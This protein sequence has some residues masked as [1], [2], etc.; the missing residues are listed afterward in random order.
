MERENA[1]VHTMKSI[2]LCL[3]YPF[4]YPRN[5]FTDRH[6]EN[7]K[8]YEYLNG[9]QYFFKTNTSEAPIEEKGIFQKAYKFGPIDN[10]TFKSERITINV[11][12]AILYQ[13]GMF[14]Y[15]YPMQ[16]LHCIPAYTEWDAMD[17]MPGW[18]KAFGDKYLEELR[19]QL[20][21]DHFLYQFRIVDIKE[22]YG[23]LRLYCAC[24]TDP[25]YRIID[26]YEDL[27]Y[28]TCIE[29]GKPA[30]IITDGYVLPYCSH[31][32]WKKDVYYRIGQVKIDGKWCET[33]DIELVPQTKKDE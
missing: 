24:A 17:S 31:C 2:W 33:E 30:D 5:R 8:F 15:N 22:K 26:K 27:S 4:L 3:R 19:A 13:V 28:N 11:W 16:W 23:T 25:V 20:K 7:W 10:E 29:C 9:K 6:Y 14:I 12:Y 18:K 32:Y 21:K 1:F